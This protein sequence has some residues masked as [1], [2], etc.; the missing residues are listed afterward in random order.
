[1]NN[2][3]YVNEELKAMKQYTAD[4]EDGIKNIGN[5]FKNVK[6]KNDKTTFVSK[7]GGDIAKMLGLGKDTFKKDKNIQDFVDKYWDE[8]SDAMKSSG[9]TQIK[10]M[11]KLGQKFRREMMSSYFKNGKITLGDGVE[12]DYEEFDQKMQ[13][14]IE[15]LQKKYS[16]EI[17]INGEVNLSLDSDD[18]YF[19][20]GISS[21]LDQVA[22]GKKSIEDAVSTI[23]G[24]YQ[25]ALDVNS[26]GWQEF[27]AARKAFDDAF[28][29]DDPIGMAAAA[30]RME[31][32]KSRIQYT[33]TNES[34]NNNGLFSNNA[35]SSPGGSPGGKGGS[36][37]G[38]G[39]GGKG[40]KKNPKKKFGE[41]TNPYYTQEKAIDNLNS[42]LDKLKDTQDKTF[43]LDR[44][45]NLDLQNKNIKN[46]I[47]LVNKEIAI[48]NKLA[49]Q[50]EDI[51][52]K[53]GLTF[54]DGIITNYDEIVEKE[55]QRYNKSKRGEKQTERW[56]E[57]TQFLE[58]Y[59]SNITQ[60]YQAL[61]DQ[62]AEHINSIVENQISKIDTYVEIHVDYSDMLE[63]WQDFRRD[64]IN[65]IKDDDYLNLNKFALTSIKE[66]VDNG[67]VETYR[68]EMTKA[69]AAIQQ[70]KDSMDAN[71]QNGISTD[72]WND[73]N[74]AYED[75][76]E[77]M[78]GIMESWTTIK[79]MVDETGENYVSAIEKASDELE[80]QV[81]LYELINDQYEHDMNILSTL[82]GEDAYAQLQNYYELQVQ[83]NALSV[84]MAAKT[85]NMFRQAYDEAVASGNQEAIDA[86]EEAWENS[87][88]NLN[89]IVEEALETIQNKYANAVNA[90]I[91]AMTDAL[92][93]ALGT[94][95]LDEEMTSIIDNY[96][97]YLD[98]V[99]RTFGLQD[100]AS[101]WQNAIDQSDNVEV[102][103]KLNQLMQDQ[104]SYL[105]EKGEL[106]E[107]DLERAE[108]EYELALK[109][110]ALQEAQQNKSKIRLMRDANGNYVY[111]YTSDQEAI[112]K[113]Q[114][115]LAKA[116]NDLY[117]FDED[118]FEQNMSDIISGYEEMVEKMTKIAADETLTQE[119][120]YAKQLEIAENYYKRVGKLAR[121]QGFIEGNLGSSAGLA[122][123]QL[124]EIGK[125]SSLLNSSA[126][127]FVN[128]INSNGFTD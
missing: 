126:Y 48:T 59:D 88:S 12:V 73:E 31:A 3:H 110:I 94:E 41:D 75:M 78:E 92:T 93:A 27:A 55:R 90:S 74:S 107:Y 77:A 5:A 84:D 67:L 42:S 8:F 7:N 98:E 16:E 14:G 68:T 62:V 2:E 17:D 58:D 51:G 83:N 100:L 87:I 65:D 36:G 20:Q 80:K 128:A 49:A 15:E 127:D 35:T 123:F 122:G 53:W 117:N 22:N 40:G 33:L 70:Y 11:S 76:K 106:T 54:K 95:L 66:T 101:K 118:R 1:M 21:I 125:V 63:T 104:L 72:Y 99:N 28:A 116:Q 121:E 85:M 69:Y 113:A 38:G 112:A 29:G 82:Y 111:K 81:S 97:V 32:A 119:Q 120:K 71:S 39:K 44:V 64:I 24:S 108:K 105:E 57:F 10:K 114:E 79:E 30:V 86:A 60:K 102:Q 43:G 34:G 4:I 91:T 50:E 45:K 89:D 56:E 115:E 6:D 19:N 13:N 18:N 46:Q 25:V 9:D 47:D 109:Q 37:G 124:S 61:N 52:K 26:E 96:D 103:Q 23:E